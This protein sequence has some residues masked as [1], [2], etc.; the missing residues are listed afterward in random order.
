MIRRERDVSATY[1]QTLGAKLVRGRHF[2]E[3]DDA[4]KPA[5]ASH[6]PGICAAPLSG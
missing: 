4:S 2:E 1:F 3:G 5:V 6:Q